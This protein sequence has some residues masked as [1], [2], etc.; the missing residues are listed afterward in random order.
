MEE[1]YRKKMRQLKWNSVGVGFFGLLS[2]LAG[3]YLTFEGSLQEIHTAGLP[4]W[5][6]LIVDLILIMIYAVGFMELFVAYLGVKASKGEHE[7]AV[8]VKYAKIL[9]GLFLLSLFINILDEGI[10]VLTGGVIAHGATLFWFIY[11]GNGILELE[12]EFERDHRPS[13]YGPVGGQGLGYAGGLG[14]QGNISPSMS[15]QKD[16]RE[17]Y[18]GHRMD[19]DEDRSLQGIEQIDPSIVEHQSERSEEDPGVVNLKDDL[20]ELNALLADLGKK[21]EI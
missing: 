16:L 9:F 14:Y 20:T 10:R 2:L 12:K 3:L 4:F 6:V 8:A 17:E 18:R 13:P 11:H 1:V 21:E 19:Y 7:I 5:A 15:T